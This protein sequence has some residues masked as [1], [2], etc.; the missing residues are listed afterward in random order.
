MG[1]DQGEREV[2]RSAA[3]GRMV[4]WGPIQKIRAVETRSGLEYLEDLAVF[5]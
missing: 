2:V 4:T 5:F 3:P 1:T